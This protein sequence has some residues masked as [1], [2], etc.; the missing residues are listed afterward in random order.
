MYLLIIAKRLVGAHRHGGGEQA[1]GN[2]GAVAR[3]VY[4]D[5]VEIKV[6]GFWVLALGLACIDGWRGV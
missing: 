2:D 3:G 6:D 4:L 5:I 1:V